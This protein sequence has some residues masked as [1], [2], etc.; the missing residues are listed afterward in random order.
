[1][2]NDLKRFGFRKDYD[3]H[4]RIVKQ[5]SV[6]Y[7]GKKYW[8]STVDLGID[9][10]F[11]GIP[12]YYETMIFA[13]EENGD[14]NYRDLYCDRYTTKEQALAEHNKLIDLFNNHK[15]ELIDGYFKEEM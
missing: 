4:N 9:Y 11:D 15:I 13:I 8:V 2:N 6:I 1:M 12:L 10:G 14:I 7:K 5:E 3:E